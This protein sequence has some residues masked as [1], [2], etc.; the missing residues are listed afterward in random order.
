MEAVV[1]QHRL[2]IIRSSSEPCCSL[3]H[4]A[5]SHDPPVCPKASLID[6]TTCLWTFDKIPGHDVCH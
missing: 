5:A 4:A 3:P 6:Y 2:S 1:D